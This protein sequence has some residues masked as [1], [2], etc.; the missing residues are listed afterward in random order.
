[1]VVEAPELWIRFLGDRSANEARPRLC[2]KDAEGE[3]ELVIKPRDRTFIAALAVPRAMARRADGEGRELPVL[4]S[5]EISDRTSSDRSIIGRA[6]GDLEKIFSE[7]GLLLDEYL[8]ANKADSQYGLRGAHVDVMELLAARDAPDDADRLL[9]EIPNGPASAGLTQANSA[10]F[11]TIALAALDEVLQE[12]AQRAKESG[13]AGAGD[14]R[15]AKT[16][17]SER[18]HE[19]MRGSRRARG[20][21]EPAAVGVPR[22]AHLDR[23]RRLPGW[24]KTLGAVMAA[25]TVIAVV[26]AIA[27]GGGG[28]SQHDVQ[29][30]PSA[31]GR[32]EITGGAARTWSNYHNAGGT[33]GPSLTMHRRVYVTCRV[34][35][36]QAGGTNVWW[37]RLGQPP[38]SN[39]FYASADGFY[40]NG[41]SSGPL[42][43]T[44]KIDGRVPLCP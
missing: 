41:Q 5:Q 22:D 35:G 7:H 42:K 44:P 36:F 26:I 17:P 32:F 27:G 11:N 3:I 28:S 8:V 39:R 1:M 24:A 40:N 30:N 29:P 20:S 34:R 38:W 12:A 16:Q 21:D 13:A 31:P 19:E 4:S 33:P 6:L 14:G 9:E 23:G 15:A 2:L 43:G 25:V 37:Y 18:E 10:L